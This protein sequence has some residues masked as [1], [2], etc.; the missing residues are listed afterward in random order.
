[1]PCILN[2][3]NEIVV[4]AFLN[5]KI[6]FLSMS[7]VIENCMEKIAFVKNPALEDYIKTNEET[8]ALARK[9]L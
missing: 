9:L 8:R 3:A 7:D 5:D 4:E 2:A 1:M 6:R